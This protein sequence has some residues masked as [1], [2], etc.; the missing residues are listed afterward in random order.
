[1]SI[2]S[3]TPNDPANFTPTLGDYK[4]LK[5]FR[6]WCQKVLPLVYDDS[7]SYYELLCKIVDYLNKTM[8]DVDT[9]HGDVTNLHKAYEEL[10]TYVN[11]Y[12][13]NLDVQ[14]EIN[15]KLDAMASDGTLIAIISPTIS[16][17]TSKWLSKY[18][19]N[20]NNPPIDSSLSVSSAAADSKTVG[21][22]FKSKK[23]LCFKKINSDLADDNMHLFNS[24]IICGSIKPFSK[25]YVNR[26]TITPLNINI[27]FCDENRNNVIGFYT[28]DT[29]KYSGYTILHLSSLDNVHSGE[30]LINFNVNVDYSSGI[31]EYEITENCFDTFNYTNEIDNSLTSDTEPPSS[32]FIGKALNTKLSFP[33]ICSDYDILNESINKISK[34]ILSAKSTTYK[35]LYISRCS[36]NGTIHQIDVS[37]YS[38]DTAVG[39]FYSSESYSGINVINITPLNSNIVMQLLVNFD[40]FNDVIDFAMDKR[41]FELS[42]LCFSYTEEDNS[43]NNCKDKNW[44]AIGDS[45][46]EQNIYPYFVDK[47]LQLKSVYNAGISGAGMKDM[48]NKLSVEGLGEYD[49]CTVF[50]GTN[51]FGAGTILGNIS[52]DRT[53][54]T[55]YGYTKNVIYNILTGKPNINLMFITPLYRGKF[56]NQPGAGETNSAGFKLVDYVNAI[57]DVCNYYSIPVLNLFHTGG[58][59]EF[60]ISTYTDDNLHPN[61]KGGKLIANKIAMFMNNN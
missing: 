53:A 52:D 46:T 12:F 2:R 59:N 45:I 25:L 42:P 1:M 51:D 29:S 11:N 43:L 40:A 27:V 37:D 20:P 23:W 9:L 10:Q 28:T 5:P 6:F 31:N 50:C 16:D 57:I 38:T 3:I 26:L 54:S 32:A 55:F 15:N 44:Y 58:F 41:I 48:I 35:K 7:L 8:E 17:E 13:K 19:T 22:I 21:D 30:I 47:T 24:A 61:Q 60:T 34:I 56:D 33:F 4:E 36:F 49:I 14:N 18:I 39:S